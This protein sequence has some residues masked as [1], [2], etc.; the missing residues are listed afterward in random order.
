MKKRISC[1]IVN[2]VSIDTEER[3]IQLAKEPHENFNEADLLQ[4]A[5]FWSGQSH[6]SINVSAFHVCRQ[7]V[8]NAATG[9][10]LD[11]LA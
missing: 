5:H 1:R 8:N 9:Q 10:I 6:K 3:S 2:S 11:F 7:I 4:T